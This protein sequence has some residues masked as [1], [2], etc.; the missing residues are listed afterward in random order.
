MCGL[1]M[2][3]TKNLN[4]F[5]AQQQ[6]I[7]ASLLYI[8]GGFRGRDG[9]GV[10][11]IDNV[12]N[13]QLAKE[14]CSVDS[15]LFTKEY[16]EL[17]SMAYKNGMAMIGHNRAAT[18]GSISDKN[19]HP[20]IIDDKIVL[21]HNGTFYGDHKKIKDTEV[22]SEVIGHLLLENDNIEEALKKVNAAYALMW[23]NVED[24]EIYVIRNSSR[25]LYYMETASSYIYASEES[26]LD[27]VVTK[28]N[29][30]LER[31]PYLI[32]EHNLNK[33]KLLDD[34]SIETSNHDLECTPEYTS[35]AAW[36]GWTGKDNTTNTYYDGIFTKALALSKDIVGVTHGAWEKFR[37]KMVT[38]K[39]LSVKVVDF[40]EEK[41]SGG[42]DTVVIGHTLGDCKLNVYFKLY[43]K[44]MEEALAILSDEVFL[45]DPSTT[46]WKRVEEM[47][48]VDDKTP[49]E[50][51]MGVPLV[52][53]YNP[54]P[55]LGVENK[56]VH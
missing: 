45:V 9:V 37:Q 5:N 43:G 7:F 49:M 32:A 6:D 52:I 42:T 25:T 41:F 3:I 4:G 34:G 2:V 55:L 15:F 12:G 26:F 30:K 11:V 35:H 10:T 24:K 13:V 33:Y 29:L 1:V 17:N 31:G 21:V 46:M 51:W 50:E 16:E 23:Y 18:K 53:A 22:D 8:S 28:F 38:G 56:N 19:S 36:K 54:V 48:P 44:S 27:F 40:S 14:A 39:K 47:Y 20:F